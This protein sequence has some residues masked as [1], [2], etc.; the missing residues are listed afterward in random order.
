MARAAA[1]ANCQ[2]RRRRTLA[3]AAR[4]VGGCE[5]RVGVANTKKKPCWEFQHFVLESTK[6]NTIFH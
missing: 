1:A 2:L 5:N 3:A 4:G 6:P